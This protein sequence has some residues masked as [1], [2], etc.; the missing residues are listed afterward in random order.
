MIEKSGRRRKTSVGNKGGRS[1]AKNTEE[2][3]KYYI[4]GRRRTGLTD[5]FNLTISSQFQDTAERRRS[6]DIRNALE[7]A[8]IDRVR[9]HLT[10][11]ATEDLML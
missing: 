4:G 1:Q 6:Q 11:N 2:G 10:S 8:E 7:P 5:S 9:N 3:D